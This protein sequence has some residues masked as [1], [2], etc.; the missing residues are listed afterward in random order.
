MSR[1]LV[2]AC[3]TGRSRS[4]RVRARGAALTA[5]LLVL[6]SAVVASP[7]AAQSPAEVADAFA[8]ACTQAD[9]T[10]LEELLAPRGVV[11]RLDDA[12][13]VSVTPRQA[14]ASLERFLERHEAAEVAVRR[15]ETLGG[16]PARAMAELAW[17][18]LPRGTRERAARVIF[19]GL[20]LIADRWTVVEIRLLF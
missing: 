5:A 19:L 15:T 16:E 17:A 14:A 1:P 6:L 9:R 20:E 4:A 7:A 18:A 3:G 13:H 2:G 11:L 10:R 8:R 12:G